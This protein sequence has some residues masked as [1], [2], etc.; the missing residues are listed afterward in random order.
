MVNPITS[1]S[2]PRDLSGRGHPSS[3]I[4][5]ITYRHT[6]ILT[7]FLAVKMGGAA[8]VFLL[9]LGSAAAVLQVKYPAMMAAALSG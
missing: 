6:Q 1:G 5:I 2:V 9:A 7:H 8:Q 4:N 3:T